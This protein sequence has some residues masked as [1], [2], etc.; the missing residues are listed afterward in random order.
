MKKVIPS[1][2]I[3][4]KSLC[5]S[6]EKA[7]IPLFLRF[8]FVCLHD[9]PQVPQQRD[10]NWVSWQSLS[11][12]TFSQYLVVSLHSTAKGEKRRRNG[13]EVMNKGFLAWEHISLGGQE[14]DPCVG[15][16]YCEHELDLLQ[17][18]N[19]DCKP[20]GSVENWWATF[21]FRAW[22]KGF[23]GCSTTRSVCHL[24]AF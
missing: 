21:A 19:V 3:F 14:E 12:F 23:W 6:E 24:P 22:G 17:R 20:T 16:S 5:L 8:H 18:P 10:L 4:C 11:C 2:C 15:R 1:I 7:V 13:D 9:F